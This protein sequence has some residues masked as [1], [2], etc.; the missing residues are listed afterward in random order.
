MQPKW[1]HME[2][3]PK[4]CLDNENKSERENFTSAR[5]KEEKNFRI[6]FSLS[7]SQILLIAFWAL[8]FIERSW[9]CTSCTLH[10]Q[11]SRRKNGS[12]VLCF[13]SEWN[14][15]QKIPPIGLNHH[16]FVCMYI[17]KTFFLENKILSL[18]HTPAKLRLASSSSSFDIE[19]EIFFFLSIHETHTHTKKLQTHWKTL[20]RRKKLFVFCVLQ[21]FGSREGTVKRLKWKTVWRWENCGANIFFQTQPKVSE[22][23]KFPK[24][25]K[26]IRKII[27]K[28]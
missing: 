11:K 27:K 5:K 16:H 10:M 17:H 4:F 18:E 15:S 22:K 28:F 26:I 6:V 13:G 2:V 12:Q 14:C 7:R 23:F 19:L 24:C 8:H 3:G 21:L 9:R 20:M 1:N 25:D